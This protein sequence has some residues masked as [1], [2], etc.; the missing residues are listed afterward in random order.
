M[1]LFDDSSSSST[2]QERIEDSITVQ[3]KKF[4]FKNFITDDIKKIWNILKND[5]LNQYEMK[6][7]ILKDY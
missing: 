7:N 5:F 1:N 4:D 3:G 6:Q 2:Q